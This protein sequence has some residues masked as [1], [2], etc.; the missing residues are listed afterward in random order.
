MKGGVHSSIGTLVVAAAFVG[1]CGVFTPYGGSDPNGLAT[2][3]D[4]SEA[5]SPGDGAVQPTA[6]GTGNNELTE[7]GTTSGGSDGGTGASAYCQGHTKNQLVCQDFDGPQ[8]TTGW[9]NGV[10]DSS[11]AFS[12]TVVATATLALQGGDLH[13]HS[14]APSDDA[15]ISTLKIMP[16]PAYFTVVVK[17]HA[18]IAAGGSLTVLQLGFTSGAHVSLKASDTALVLE[19]PTS[20]TSVSVNASMDRVVTVNYS[21][22]QFNVSLST[23]EQF[24]VPYGPDVLTATT[25]GA[26]KAS[27]ASSFDTFID[28]YLVSSP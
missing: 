17:F 19:T 26:L 11:G 24:M 10:L 12:S 8:I 4:A 14:A 28:Y 22:G 5:A 3:E 6:D 13:A 21:A 9:L 20:V 16:A 7:G 1:A 2:Y 27:S 18:T 25:V 23:G 15:F